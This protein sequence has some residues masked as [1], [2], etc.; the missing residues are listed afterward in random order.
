M[1]EE[2]N[3][4]SSRYYVDIMNR[5]L[6]KDLNISD[7]TKFN[8]KRDLY[9]INTEFY[10][11]SVINTYRNLSLIIDKY[12]DREEGAYEMMLDNLKYYAELYNNPLS[13]GNINM[14]LNGNEKIKDIKEIMHMEKRLIDGKVE[15]LEIVI[16]GIKER[17][18]KE[19]N[20]SKNK[21][22]L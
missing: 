5:K 17:N 2:G 11:P 12:K 15:Y 14:F 4:F 6:K 8:I 22:D 1:V 18:N 3:P 10:D 13:D 9:E 20:E 19:N 16:R 7:N 21:G